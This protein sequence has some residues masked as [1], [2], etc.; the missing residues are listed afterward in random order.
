MSKFPRNH[1]LQMRISLD[2][3]VRKLAFDGLFFGHG[4]SGP[5][6][7]KQQWLHWLWWGLVGAD[8]HPSI[9]LQR[10]S[11]RMMAQIIC[12]EQWCLLLGVGCDLLHSA[13]RNFHPIGFP[14]STKSEISHSSW[15]A[16]F[17]SILEEST[18]GSPTK[19]PS[20][21]FLCSASGSS[22]SKR[23]AS[24]RMTWAWYHAWLA[25]PCRFS[26]LHQTRSN[27]ISQILLKYLYI[28]T[29]I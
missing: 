7:H 22:E 4:S 9:A 23:P 27:G 26:M 6:I 16:M 25:Q 10:R 1:K 13:S 11:I 29:Y 18:S 20:K 14:F 8:Q 2:C 19:S 5:S 15:Q 24:S 21:A 17:H 12:Y 3:L 28:C